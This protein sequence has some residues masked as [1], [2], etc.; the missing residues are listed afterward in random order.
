MCRFHHK[1]YFRGC[2]VQHSN[3]P[4]IQNGLQLLEADW[5]LMSVNETRG[6]VW[7]MHLLI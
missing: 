5:A 3:F 1:F 4:L 7:L 2:T 6:S